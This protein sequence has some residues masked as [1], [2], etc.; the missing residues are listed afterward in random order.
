M[1]LPSPDHIEPGTDDSSAYLTHSADMT[2]A[3]ISAQVIREY[4][5]YMKAKKSADTTIK[6]AR[7]ILNGV[8]W[9]TETHILAVGESGLRR[10]QEIRAEELQPRT[11]RTHI[12]YVRA[13]FRWAVMLGRIEADPSWVLE[14]PRTSRLLPRPMSEDR[15]AKALEAADGD[16]L[17]IICLAGFAGARACEISRLDWSDVVL[18]GRQPRVR[19]TGK[20]GHERMVDIAAPVADALAQLPHR[21]GPVIRRRDGKAG[22]VTP[23]RISQLASAFL[24]KVGIEDRLHTLRHRFGTR[25]YEASG[26]DIRATQEALGHQSPGTTAGYAALVRGSVRAA[27]L[28]ASEVHP[29]D[30]EPEAPTAPAGA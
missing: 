19:L 17:A 10:W 1:T 11:L 20:G 5:R 13:F 12:V 7:C 30:E 28:G 24:D 15:F 14:S 4:L 25:V 9:R 3:L 16:T 26:G 22:R 2:T 8:S 27:I 29:Y 21:H 6:T 18:T 23:T